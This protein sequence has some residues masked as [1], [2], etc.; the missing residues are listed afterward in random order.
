LNWG[1]LLPSF[2]KKPDIDPAAIID[3]AAES[4][5]ITTADLDAPGPTIVY[6]NPAFERMTGWSSLEVLGKTPR[7]FQGPKTEGRIFS[8]MKEK[9]LSG[10][11]WEGQ[12]INYKKDGSEFWMEWSIVPLKNENGKVYQYVAVQRDVSSRVEAE[13]SLQKAQAAKRFAEQARANLARYFSPKLVET[14]VAK[15]QP[16]GDVKR[17][18]MAVLFADIVGFTRLAEELEPEQVVDILRE[19]HIW[20]EKAI[21]KWDGSIEGFIGDAVLAIFGFPEPSEK[22]ATNAL[23]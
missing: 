22:D 20:V 13:R 17:Q 5:L 3:A 10:K 23:S 2:D 4:I 19:I 15:D 12:T 8:D 9:L 21:F 14:L 1:S 11:L 6:V 18:K 16:L 7:I